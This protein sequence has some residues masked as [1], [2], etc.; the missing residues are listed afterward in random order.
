MGQRLPCLP[1]RGWRDR[2]RLH[3]EPDC[4][5]PLSERLPGVLRGATLHPPWLQDRRP[6]AGIAAHLHD[7]EA[8]PSRGEHPAGE[9][10]VNRPREARRLPARG[11]LAA[12]SKDFRT[13]AR[14]P[15]VGDD[16]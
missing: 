10:R 15:T 2:R 4:P 11:L 7:H 1:N 9:R 12:L 14:P 3:A 16:Y 8:T 6:A 13:L 5:A